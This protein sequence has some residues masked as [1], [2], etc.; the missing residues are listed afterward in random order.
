MIDTLHGVRAG[1]S[2]ELFVDRNVEELA[3]LSTYLD[4]RVP[5]VSLS[6]C[7]EGKGDALTVDDSTIASADAARLARQKGHPVTLFLNGYNIEESVPYFFSRLNAILDA[8]PLEEVVLGARRFDLRT[9][10]AK[11]QFRQVV[12]RRLAVMASERDRQNYVTRVGERLQAADTVV[13]D[14]LR[15]ISAADVRE[16]VALGVDIQNHGWTH[17]RPAALSPDECA[18]DIQAGRAWL[19]DFSPVPA[20]LYA[21]PNGDCLPPWESSPHYRAWFLLDARWS[22]D[23]DGPTIF[24]RRNLT[25]AIMESELSRREQP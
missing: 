19:R 21:V 14:F 17:V 25:S 6:A 5:Y 2:C 16:L 24:G 7:L 15:P 23:K 18:R 12:K 3:S 8:T 1:A 22:A 4:N 20:D 13:P 11:Q 9:F 10:A